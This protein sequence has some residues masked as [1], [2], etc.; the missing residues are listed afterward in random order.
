MT[1]ENLIIYKTGNKDI[2]DGNNFKVRRKNAK[3]IEKNT[4]KNY[5]LSQVMMLINCVHIQQITHTEVV[6]RF[7]K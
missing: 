2:Q 3:E 6:G 5:I 7:I 4:L 1:K